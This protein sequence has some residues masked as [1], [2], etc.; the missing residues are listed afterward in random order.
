[1]AK[2]NAKEVAWEKVEVLGLDGLFTELRVEKET[3]P[4]GWYVYEVRHD[5]EDWSEPVEIALGVMVN[6][7]GTLL[8]EEPIELEPNAF[9]GNDYRYI[10]WDQD[11]WF[12]GET[13]RF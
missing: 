9:N 5:D 12:V 10:D 2:V 8:V 4:D 11:W 7:Y 3:I 13:V 6:F 1:M